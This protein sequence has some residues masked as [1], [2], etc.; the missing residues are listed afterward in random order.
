MTVWA[1][2]RRLP[3]AGPA[4]Q[5]PPGARRRAG[6]A[7]PLMPGETGL[8]GEDRRVLA[9]GRGTQGAALLWLDSLSNEAAEMVNSRARAGLAADASRRTCLTAAGRARKSGNLR[10]R[11]AGRELA[12]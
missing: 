10:H 3:L 11:R 5:I 8:T 9:A 4:G 6:L 2:R 1:T 12:G 7:I